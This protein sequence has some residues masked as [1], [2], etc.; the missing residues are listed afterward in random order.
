MQVFV[1]TVTPESLTISWCNLLGTKMVLLCHAE[2]SDEFENDCSGVLVVFF[3][4]LTFCL[5]Y[6][7]LCSAIS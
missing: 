5:W 3:T 7:N 1:T 6:M 2:S 4:C